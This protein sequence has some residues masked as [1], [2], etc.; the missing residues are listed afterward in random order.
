[1]SE[2]L[3]F[4]PVQCKDCYRCLREC[5]V[6]A[7]NIKD[8]HAQIIEE[9]CILCGHCTQVCP[10]KAKI[11][12]S[13]LPV[14]RELLKSGV[15]VAATVAPS[16]ISSLNQDDF[17]L[18]RIALAKLG[19]AVVQET[20][21]GAQAVTEEYKRLLAKGEM[22]N[23]ITSACPAACR[24]IQMYYPKALQY[25]APV[26]SPM[27]AHAKMLRR[28]DPD[29]KVVFIG[30]CIAKKRE[31]DE[32]GI[33]A[34]LTFEEL[35]QLF[36]ENDIDLQTINHLAAAN[37]NS[38]ANLAKAYPATQGIIRSF[39]VLP[40]GYR[41]LAVDGVDRLVD[42]LENIESLDHT[43]IEMNVCPGGCIN[44][45]CAIA[46]QGGMMKAE[47]DIN[48]YMEHEMATRKRQ[49]APQAG[50]DLGY[51]H[52][53]LR[54]KSRP[55]TEKEIEDI[56]HRT[57]KFSKA[58]ELNCG[59]CG[60]PTCR[61]KAWAVINGYADIDICLPYM[62]KRAESL[63]VDI[64][65]NSP[66]GVILVDPEMNIVDINAS[67]MSMLGLCG[68][69]ENVQGRPVSDCFPPI[70][71]YNAYSQKKRV[72]NPCLRIASTGRYVSLTVSLLSEQ[73]LLFGLMKD[74]SDEVN[75][76]KKLDKV[77]MDTI[78]TTDDLI[79]KQMRVAQEIASLLG[80]TTAETK[81]AL[82]KLKKMLSD[83]KG[84]LGVDGRPTDWKTAKVN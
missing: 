32:H 40:D 11:E 84:D 83:G 80:E 10:Q 33:D 13:E 23:F 12:H 41:Y 31:A 25:L 20:A 62:R 34:V 24:L 8:H 26:D 74:I 30:P 48:A 5:P 18:L 76:E 39:D 65:H 16:F 15:R 1:M 73:N 29:L 19:F 50:V 21:V 60:Y 4:K 75:Y 22:R 38:G 27:V 59:A 66:E 77:K 52:P 56:M 61:E 55:A 53:R 57:G 81:V 46:Q 35:L 28:N 45:P 17:S 36:A 64:V 2:Y 79:M 54:S 82:L 43:F 70:E 51:A 7:I 71:F 58:D 47:A 9:H 6:K 63:A 14:V 42:V 72:E 3:E 78:A 44:G 67:A 49:P 69:P 37:D 68:T